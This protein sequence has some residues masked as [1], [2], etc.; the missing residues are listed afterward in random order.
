MQSNLKLRIWQLKDV[1][2]IVRVR[3]TP[4]LQQWFKQ[5]HDLTDVEQVDFM[6]QVAPKCGYYGFIVEVKDNP[7]GIIALKLSG[8]NEA[9]FSIAILPE[10]QQQG[11]SQETMQQ[12]IG[13]AFNEFRLKRVYGDVFVKNPALSFFLHKCGFV[14]T[15]VLANKYIKKGCSIDVVNIEQTCY[16]SPNF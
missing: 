13:V 5:D 7:I 4:E 12:L 11:Y 14:A 2:F 10:H 8:I 6:T 1:D 3:N 9:E 15:S 16:G